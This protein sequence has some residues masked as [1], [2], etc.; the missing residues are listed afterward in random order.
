MRPVKNYAEATATSFNAAE[1]LPVGGYVL[2]IL[3]VKEEN[4]T[5]GD[6]IVLRFDIAGGEHKDF[7]QKQYDNMSDEYKKWKGTYRLNVPT[8][9]S[10]SEEDQKKYKRALGFFKAQIEALN[11]SNNIN[12]DCSR[13]WD[14]KILKGKIIGAVFGNKEWE[15]DGKTGWFTNCDHLV[16]VAD[17]RVGKFTIPKDKPLK[18]K[19]SVSTST[20]TVP[21]GLDDFEEVDG[22][23]PVPF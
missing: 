20:G 13:E 5:W 7:F 23:Q 3:D 22:E 19:S 4:Y 11:Q 9:R 14:V 6:V 17:I 16:S 15:Y 1:R 18:N 2:K 10:D 8:P 12:I 21:G